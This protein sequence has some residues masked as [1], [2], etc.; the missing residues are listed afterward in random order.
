MPID[1]FLDQ[2]YLT[3]VTVVAD[4]RSSPN[5]RHSHFCMNYLKPTLKNAGI[6]YVFMGKELGGRPKDERLYIGGVADY[7][8]MAEEEDFK[9]GMQRLVDGASRHTIALMCSEYNP[10][11]CHRCLLVGRAL[12]KRGIEVGHI[13][14]D[15]TV[16]EHDTV[17]KKLLQLTRGAEDDF[18][19]PPLERLNR[20]YRMRSLKVAYRQKSSAR[21]DLQNQE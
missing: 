4:V 10:L 20:A 13:M 6:D 18:F 7:E 16:V 17:E 14:A 11:D 1:V 19:A 2:L 12:N 3:G 5:S 21:R 15:A 8:K 9:A